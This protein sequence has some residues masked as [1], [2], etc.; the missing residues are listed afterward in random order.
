MA[1]PGGSPKLGGEGA[2]PTQPLPRRKP[3][4]YSRLHGALAGY[5]SEGNRI[6]LRRCGRGRGGRRGGAVTATAWKTSSAT[7]QRAPSRW[8]RVQFRDDLLPGFEPRQ[9][10][11]AVRLICREAQTG[12]PVLEVFHFGPCATL[13]FFEEGGMKMAS[14]FLRLRVLLLAAAADLEAG[15]YLAANAER[16]ALEAAD[17]S[18]YPKLLPLTPQ[19]Y[20]ICRCAATTENDADQQKFHPG[21]PEPRKSERRRPTPPQSPRLPSRNPDPQT[22]VR[23]S[24]ED[25]GVARNATGRATRQKTRRATR[26]WAAVCIQLAQRP[27]PRSGA[28]R[29]P[30]LG[31]R[32]STRRPPAAN[33]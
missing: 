28:L 12:R 15:E 25:R 23:A 6:A 31:S 8:G 17:V 20:L 22:E 14:A 11:P 32:I 4:D 33:H 29:P 13:P 26:D 5:L 16:R 18:E 19:H 24:A 27:G 7:W 2:Q 30:G 21:T 10:A 9:K 3:A 1:R